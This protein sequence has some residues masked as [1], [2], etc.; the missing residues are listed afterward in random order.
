MKNNRGITLIELI[1]VLV[2]IGVI[3]SISFSVLIFGFR[4]FNIQTSSIDNQS[5]V[6]SVI[7]D[8]TKE[9]RKSNGGIEVTST[10]IEF[11]ENGLIY[12]F[13]GDKLLKNGNIIASGIKSFNPIIDGNKITVEIISESQVGREFSLKSEIYIRE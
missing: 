3:I 6:R 5:I 12:D 13:Q 4:I 1:I 11:K 2:T 10:S 8:I 9:I 7:R